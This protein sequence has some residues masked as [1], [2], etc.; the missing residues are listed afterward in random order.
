M[1]DQHRHHKQEE[2]RGFS[3][4]FH[5]RI[6]VAQASYLTEDL[7]LRERYSSKVNGALS[8]SAQF[9]SRTRV[10]SFAFHYEPGGNAE[11]DQIDDYHDR[12]YV[13]NGQCEWH[14]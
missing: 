14:T 7:D 1:A 4:G 12:N 13:T 10:G 2:T 9:T 5:E 6:S 8:R 11:A 3:R